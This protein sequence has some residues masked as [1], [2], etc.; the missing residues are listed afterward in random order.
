MEV[1]RITC[2]VCPN[3]CQLNITKEA[4]EYKI[5]GNLCSRGLD[6]GMS[7]MTNPRRTVC[8]TVKTIFKEVPRLSVRTNGEISKDDIWKVMNELSKVVIEKPVSIND[9]IIKNIIDSGIDVIATTNLKESLN[10]RQK[11]G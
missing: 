5:Q 9:I 4:G 7:E 6:F 3:S 11:N 2:I 10:W 8:S 1:K